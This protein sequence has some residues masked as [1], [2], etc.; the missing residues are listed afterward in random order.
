M[1]QKKMMMISLSVMHESV[2]PPA[3]T[4]YSRTVLRLRVG[5]RT[6]QTAR[7]QPPKPG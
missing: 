1:E 5:A 2:Y 6:K 7:K 4:S 3:S